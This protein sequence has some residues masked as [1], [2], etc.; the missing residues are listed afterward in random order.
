MNRTK[1]FI[2]VLLLTLG[3]SCRAQRESLPIGRG[4]LIHIQVFET[5]DLEEHI[6]V[7]D[8]GEIRLILGGTIKVAGLTPADAAAAIE[9]RLRQANYLRSP[10]VLVMVEQYA[11]EAVSV[12]GQVR[13]PGNYQIETPR[14]VL[15]VISMAGGL[16]ENANREVTI[17]RHGTTKKITYYLSNDS[18]AAL[19]ED[20]LVYPGDTIVVPKAEVVYVMGDV[21]RP[22]GYAQTTNNSQL[23]VLQAVTLAGGTPPTASLSHARLIRKQPNGTFSETPLR[24]GAMEKGKTVDIVL[25]AD[26]IVYVP[27]SYLKNVAVGAGGLVASTSSAA[28]YHF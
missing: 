5:G 1:S 27:F 17:G 11:T 26:D 2:L 28:I 13:S 25:Q 19:K 24:L 18:S 21:G 14:H 3:T 8:A 12:I 7:T 16:T 20:I 15:D 6:R 9:T 10:H 23:T 22:G 4:D